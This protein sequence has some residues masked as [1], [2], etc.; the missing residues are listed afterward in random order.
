[1][2]YEETRQEDLPYMVVGHSI[3]PSPR[4]SVLLTV[5]G[6]RELLNR[7]GED[8]EHIRMTLVDDVEWDSSGNDAVKRGRQLFTILTKSK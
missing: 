3:L 2:S 1:M 6:L 5:A 8:A 4:I 7:C